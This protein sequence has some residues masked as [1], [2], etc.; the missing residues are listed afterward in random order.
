MIDGHG[1]IEDAGEI[2][3]ANQQDGQGRQREHGLNCRD[4]AFATSLRWKGT[5]DHSATEICGS[6]PPVDPNVELNVIRPLPLRWALHSTNI[7]YPEAAV[8]LPLLKS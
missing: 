1:G 2:Q 7:V 3:R 4:P 6:W 5:H 8:R